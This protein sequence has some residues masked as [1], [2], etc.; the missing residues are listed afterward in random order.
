MILFAE[1]Y[2]KCIATFCA[3]SDNLSKAEN[4]LKTKDRKRRFSCTKAENMLKTSQLEKHVGTQNLGDKLFGQA[5]ACAGGK[6]LSF[7]RCTGGLPPP[8]SIRDRRC[9]SAIR[10]RRCNSAIGDRRYNSRFSR[11]VLRGAPAGRESGATV[12]A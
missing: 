3:S 7:A 8:S 5:G 9:N 6:R 11:R 12:A 2:G 10:D 1:T 4:I